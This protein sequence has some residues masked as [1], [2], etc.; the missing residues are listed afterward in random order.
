MIV[1]QSTTKKTV[2]KS[3]LIIYWLLLPLLFVGYLLLKS[4]LEGISLNM[5]LV[6]DPHLTVMFLLSLINPLSGYLLKELSDSEQLNS[7]FA[8]LFLKFSIGQQLVTGNLIG[9]GL[10]FLTLKENDLSVKP[11]KVTPYRKGYAILFIQTL[12]TIISL[13]ALYL[14]VRQK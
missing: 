2:F 10:A 8:Q 1:S 5:I 4:R 12:L 14:I 7:S 9:S 11:E 13:V 3:S 6:N